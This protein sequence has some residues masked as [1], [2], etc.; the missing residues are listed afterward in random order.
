MRFLRQYHV[1]T[2]SVG[3]HKN[4]HFDYWGIS[5]QQQ[6]LL[7]HLPLSLVKRAGDQTHGRPSFYGNRG[8]QPHTL[9]FPNYPEAHSKA[10]KPVVP[11]FLLPGSPQLYLLGS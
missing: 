6:D 9:H 7:Y 5:P 4:S 3:Q 11:A 8:W 2:I 10:Q 1:S